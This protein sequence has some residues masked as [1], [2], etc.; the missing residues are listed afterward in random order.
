LRLNPAHSAEGVGFEPTVGLHL[1]R[2]SRPSQS[3]TLAPLLLEAELEA[4]RASISSEHLVATALLLTDLV[5][6]IVGNE[7]RHVD[8]HR[9]RDRVARP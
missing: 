1:L 8:G 7:D 3:T 9:Q 2:F 6:N 5:D 4:L